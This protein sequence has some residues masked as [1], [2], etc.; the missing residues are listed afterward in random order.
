MMKNKYKIVGDTLIVYN[1]KDNREMLFDAEDFNLIKNRTWGIV[2]NG[3][4]RTDVQKDNKRFYLSAHRLVMKCPND[5]VVD[6][7]NHNKAD[8]RKSNLRITTQSINQHNRTA[9]GYCWDK[10]ANKWKAY[11][12]IPNKKSLHLGLYN[13]EDE[14]RAAYLEAKKKYHPTAPHHLFV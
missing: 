8:N 9:K 3:Y 6:H 10:Y 11:I 2:N 5:K 4:V 12:K 14:A 13:T 1:R 7:K